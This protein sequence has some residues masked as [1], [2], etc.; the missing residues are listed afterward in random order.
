MVSTNPAMSRLIVSEV[1]VIIIKI[2]SRLGFCILLKNLEIESSKFFV[3]PDTAIRL[4]TAKE[5]KIK[6]KIDNFTFQNGLVVS[7]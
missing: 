3:I 2:R 6:I 5:I 4:I 1:V 7:L